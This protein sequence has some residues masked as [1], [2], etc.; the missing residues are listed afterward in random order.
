METYARFQI[1][2][3]SSST[4]RHF[5]IHCIVAFTCLPPLPCV[6]VLLNTTEPHKAIS[7]SSLSFPFYTLSSF[8][9]LCVV[10]FPILF[11]IPLSLMKERSKPEVVK[12][13][14][15]NS[16]GKWKHKWKAK[17]KEG[18]KKARL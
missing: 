12:R 18:E 3:P 9:L 6:R 10:F 16:G 15:E 4:S 11:S 1:T 7:S 2:L 8:C 5:S 17:K 14:G 13:V